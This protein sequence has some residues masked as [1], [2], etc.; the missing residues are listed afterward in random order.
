M[1]IGNWGLKWSP[2]IPPSPP[3]YPPALDVFWPSRPSSR[4]SARYAKR[5]QAFPIRCDI[6]QSHRWYSATDP[7]LDLGQFH[8]IF[9][10]LSRPFHPFDFVNSFL[11]HDRPSTSSPDAFFDVC[12]Y[13]LD[14]TRLSDSRYSSWNWFP[15]RSVSVTLHLTFWMFNFLPEVDGTQL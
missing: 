2:C 10:P 13:L 8:P 4:R 11:D 9:V 7:V 14:L 15:T 1:A 12:W 6:P 3:V 5:P